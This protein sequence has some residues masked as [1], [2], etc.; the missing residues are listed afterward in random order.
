MQLRDFW[1]PIHGEIE[2]RTA[3]MIVIPTVLG[4]VVVWLAAIYSIVDKRQATLYEKSQAL[5]R[6]NGVVVAETQQLFKVVEVF[7]GTIDQWLIENPQA[8]PRVDR[9]FVR[10]V[11]SFRAKTHGQIDITVISE[12]GDV[13][14]PPADSGAPLDNA[15]K[16]DHFVA[17]NGSLAEQIS[18]G[19]PV[20]GPTNKGWLIPVSFPLHAH[21]HGISV[22]TAVIA[23]PTI[24]AMYELA[25]DK[26]GGTISLVRRD[27]MLLVRAPGLDGTVG[28]PILGHGSIVANLDARSPH[29]A[30]EQ[31]S[32][33]D[34]EARLVS[35]E[36]VQDFP[37]AVVVSAKLDDVLASWQHYAVLLI[38]IAI[39]ITGTVTLVLTN[40]VRH[41]SAASLSRLQL[42]LEA[43]T[44]PL[45]GAGNRRQFLTRTED[46]IRRSR[47]YARPLSLMLLDLDYFKTV[48]DECGHQIGDEMLTSVSF[49]IQSVLRG[50]DF[51]ARFGGDEFAVLMPETDCDEAS[52]VAERIQTAIRGIAIESCDGP[53]CV[54]ASI[55]VA[56]L[57]P[58]DA[59]AQLLLERADV[60]LYSAKRQGRNRVV[61]IGDTA[62]IES[63]IMAA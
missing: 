30:V 10:F 14:F 39:Y 46:E 61:F 5:A 47:R 9:R 45:T 13:Y 35:H 38:L 57:L 32:P 59:T 20:R 48:N 17:A 33:I 53:V 29:A 11:E 27:G 37:L 21:P 16:Q 28:K 8:D 49:A 43:A 52:T 40:V 18:I 6:V 54:T 63:A 50:T 34:G 25:R 56:A 26:P 24:S 51:L 22:V 42:A 31:H 19:V 55:G 36:I 15:R 44:D 58:E 7:L 2:R 62:P 1:P 3:R 41:L 60:A 12:D 23:V 4:L